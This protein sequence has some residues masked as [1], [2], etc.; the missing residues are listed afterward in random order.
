M[1]AQSLEGPMR[2]GAVAVVGLMIAA[3][4]QAQT[5]T[6]VFVQRGVPANARIVAAGPTCP[7]GVLRARQQAAGGTTIWTIAQEDRNNKYQRGTPASM[8]VHVAFDSRLN[9][10]Q[11]LELSVT[12]LPVKLRLMPVAP[13]EGPAPDPKKTFVLKR[14][15]ALKIDGDLMVGPAATIKTVHLISATYSDGSVWR[16]PTEDSCTVEP[17]GLLLVGAK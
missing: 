14:E 13:T 10:V 8:G 4:A 7:A 16:A 12:Y 3:G 11:S 1:E 5:Q 15:A 9:L 6:Q 17:S 2:I